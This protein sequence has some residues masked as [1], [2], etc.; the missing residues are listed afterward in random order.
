MLV[1]AGV[2]GVKV[3][4]GRDEGGTC[5]YVVSQRGKASGKEGGGEDPFFFLFFFHLF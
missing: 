2:E 3:W 4:A 1:G 5:A